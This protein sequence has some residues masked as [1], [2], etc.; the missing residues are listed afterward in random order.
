MVKKILIS[1]LLIGFVI[2]AY[3]AYSIY[4]K[5]YFPN[6]TLTKSGTEYFYIKTGSDFTDVSNSLYEKGYIK[7]RNSFEWVAQKKSNFVNNIKPGKY[8]LTEGMSNNELIDLLR[9]GKQEPVKISFDHIRTVQELSGKLS[10][11]IEAD[12]NSLYELLT[13]KEVIDKYGLTKNTILTLFI[14][15]T[16]EFYWNTSAEELI[17]RMAKEYKNFWTEERKEKAKKMNLSQSQVSTLAS[18]VQAEQSL[19]VDERPRVAGLYVNRIKNNMMLQSDPTVIYAVGDFTIK[20]V[21]GKHL[22]VDSPFNTYK[23]YGLPPGPIVL[24]SI[25]SIDAVLNYE[26]HNYIYMCAKEDFSGYHNFAVNYDE[27]QKNA[28]RYQKELNKRNIR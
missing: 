1:I 14:P 17:K 9:S 18:I 20:R 19:K 5:I 8:L 2:G 7:N 23:N 10:K 26:K 27:H 25:K 16:Y 22:S 12:S 24:P 4:S 13:E 3:L 21:T 28:R 11:N 15:N 6:V